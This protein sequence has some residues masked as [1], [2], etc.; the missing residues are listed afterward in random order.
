M[1]ARAV[2]LLA[3]EIKGKYHALPQSKAEKWES[4]IA[5]AQHRDAEG[6]GHIYQ[7]LPASTLSMDYRRVWHVRQPDGTVISIW[8]P[9]CPAGYRA[10]GDVLSQGLDPPPE[11]VK[12]G[13]C[14]ILVQS[15]GNV[16][17]M[18]P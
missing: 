5:E 6:N 12:V 17:Q 3:E 11:P 8:H 14:A 7:T 9:I 18:V 13:F 15:L 2:A 10:V 16:L 1:Q 4:R